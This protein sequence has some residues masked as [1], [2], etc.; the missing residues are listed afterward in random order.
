M[1][2]LVNE[3][4][5]KMQIKFEGT[6]D[7][8]IETFST[9]LKNTVSSLKIIA[10]EVLDDDQFCKFKITD[11][12]KG[13]FIIDVAA[14]TISN[15]PNILNNIPTVL[16]TFKTILDIKKHLKGENPKS[17]RG[18]DENNVAIENNNGEVI[19]V[20]KPVINI[21]GTNEQLEKDISNIFNKIS[22]D[23]DRKGISFRLENESGI[24][25]TS[26][27]VDDVDEAKKPI[28]VVTL[29]DNIEENIIDAIVTVVKP[30]F[31]GKSK[32]QVFLN[33]SRINVEIKD[34][35]FMKK[36]HDDEISFK[37]STRLRVKLRTRYKINNYGLPIEGSQTDYAIME[38][39]EV[40]ENRQQENMKL[41]S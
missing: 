26:F 2:I 28:D 8:D 16:T 35:L 38:V 4:V 13:S 17:V 19:N 1:L 7:I 20:Y 15:Y 39:L 23:K 25:S 37:G 27:E 22:S 29:V 5:E 34:E 40:I 18:I 41:F 6:S 30:D 3:N 31:Y 14:I 33:T 24:T 36:V 12:S 9:T 11:V 10:D 32:W 21:Y